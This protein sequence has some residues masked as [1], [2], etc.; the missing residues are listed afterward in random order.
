MPGKDRNKTA[1]GYVKIIAKVVP[2]LHR[3]RC[4]PIMAV[5][6]DAD[7]ALGREVGQYR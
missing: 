5:I 4:R 6:P 7:G 1:F 3:G 2:S